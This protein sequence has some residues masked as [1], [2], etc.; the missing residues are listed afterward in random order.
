[1]ER[2]IHH[3]SKVSLMCRHEVEK[4]CSP[5]CQNWIFFLCF[6]QPGMIYPS[7]TNSPLV[8]LSINA[9]NTRLKTYTCHKL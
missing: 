1:M 9:S 7:W 5:T 2:N 6:S 3:H 4:V 8:K